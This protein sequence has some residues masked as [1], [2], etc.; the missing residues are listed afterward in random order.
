ML[1]NNDNQ[2]IFACETKNANFIKLDEDIAELMQIIQNEMNK[3][4]LNAVILGVVKNKDINLNKLL[5]Q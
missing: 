2:K 3:R 4:K 5:L 1:S